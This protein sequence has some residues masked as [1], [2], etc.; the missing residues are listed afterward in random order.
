MI[1]GSR[2]TLYAFQ[3]VCTREVENKEKQKLSQHSPS[4]KNKF[5][6]PKIELLVMR[7]EHTSAQT[8]A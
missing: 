8:Q 2:L 5:E 1:V 7:I 4:G 3:S 6:K